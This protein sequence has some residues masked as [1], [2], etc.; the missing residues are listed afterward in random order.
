MSRTELEAG[1]IRMTFV[2]SIR[3]AHPS[4]RR[5]PDHSIQSLLGYIVKYA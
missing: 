2:G 1:L 3:E 5:D 4:W